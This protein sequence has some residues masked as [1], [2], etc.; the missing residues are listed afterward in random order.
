MD[1]KEDVFQL[2]DKFYEYKR[3]YEDKYNDIKKRKK[4]TKNWI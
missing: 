3:S 2:I 4:I 1:K